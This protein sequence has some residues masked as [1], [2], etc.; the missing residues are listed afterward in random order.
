MPTLI[1]IITDDVL[2]HALVANLHVSKAEAQQLA[3]NIINAYP[4]LLDDSYWNQVVPNQTAYQ[5]RM[6][7]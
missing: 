3:E 5:P 2:E 6:V 4:K 1:E 7:L